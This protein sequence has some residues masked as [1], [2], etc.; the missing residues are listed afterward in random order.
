MK[1]IHFS[2]NPKKS[3]K[4]QALDVIRQLSDTIPIERAQMRL[5]LTLP[6]K[7]AKALV[8]RMRPLFSTVESEEWMGDLE[9]VGTSCFLVTQYAALEQLGPIDC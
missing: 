2:V 7:N 6:K 9:L 1:D 8:E 3:S 5:R 4:Q